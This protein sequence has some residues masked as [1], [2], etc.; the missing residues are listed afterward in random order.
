MDLLNNYIEMMGDTEFAICVAAFVFGLILLI[1]LVAKLFEG[2]PGPVPAAVRPAE[3]T[4]MGLK[5]IGEKVPEKAKE[6]ISGPALPSVPASP[7]ALEGVM[8]WEFDDGKKKKNKS[9]PP[10]KPAAAVPPPPPPVGA[11][12][13]ASAPSAEIKG[14]S[15]VPLGASSAAPTRPE[16]KTVILPP[17]ATKPPAPAPLA[18]PTISVAA[19][20]PAPPK[21]E[22]V[23]EPESSFVDFQMYE[24]LVR[25][26]AGL[27]ADL[28]R[29]PLYLDPLMKR[30][31]NTEKRLEEL[32]SKGFAVAGAPAVPN[33]SPGAASETEVKELKEKVEKL[34]K[35]LERLSEG[36][37]A[38][39]PPNSSNYP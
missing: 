19:A 23:P 33:G 32:V 13:P 35:L 26:I 4:P 39:S 38:D 34:Q 28:K 1:G 31:G 16:D 36:P 10:V 14:P 21:A 30:M 8:M 25:R 11:P 2:R 17:Q 27:E 6:K 7:P 5:P 37:P 12:S 15:P 3:P 18:A 24:T 20:P 29:D 9:L 22:G